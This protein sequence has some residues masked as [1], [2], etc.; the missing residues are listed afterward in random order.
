MNSM[1]SKRAAL[2]GFAVLLGGTA[3]N[4]VLAQDTP[5]ASAPAITI[6]YSDLD[7]AQPS[8]VQA[9]YRRV[10]TAAKTVCEHGNIRDLARYAASQKCF[11]QAMS[12]AV[13]E[14]GVP[15]LNAL[16]HQKTNRRVG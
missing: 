2:L 12:K 6:H 9:L 10:A 8:G 15:Q 16:Y 7:L 1:L 4:V 13:E 14:I 5:D 3:S 11:D